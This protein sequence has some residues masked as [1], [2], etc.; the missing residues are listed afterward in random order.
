[1]CLYVSF[2]FFIVI[3]FSLELFSPNG[4]PYTLVYKNVPARAA[5]SFVIV[6]RYFMILDQFL[7]QL[8]ALV[9][10]QA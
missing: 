7:D 2:V 1:M 8:L 6:P 10:L 3:S 9:L 5:V 4:S